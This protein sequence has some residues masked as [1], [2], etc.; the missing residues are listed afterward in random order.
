[1][2]ELIEASDTCNS[3]AIV[4]MSE[5]CPFDCILCCKALALYLFSIVLDVDS[6]V[7]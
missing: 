7:P 2:S 6:A 1:M 5:I 3:C 4:A